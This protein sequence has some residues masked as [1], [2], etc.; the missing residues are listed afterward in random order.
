MME[1]DVEYILSLTLL[2]QM[3]RKHLLKAVDRSCQ[4][5]CT[6]QVGLQF[7]LYHFSGNHPNTVS[8]IKTPIFTSGSG[9]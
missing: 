6:G 3:H 7:Y 8:K 4:H 9:P 2:F 5:Y 1:G